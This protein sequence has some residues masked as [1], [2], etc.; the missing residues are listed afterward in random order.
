MRKNWQF[1]LW[2]ATAVTVIGVLLI[3]S[4][5]GNADDGWYG[6]A[7]SDAY[8]YI[9]M[10]QGD[11]I[12]YPWGGRWLVPRMASLADGASVG[13]LQALNYLF[14]FLAVA[15]I[16]YLAAD[17]ASSTSVMVGA[18]AFSATGVALLVL[19]QNPFLVD[20]G[21]LFVFALIGIA[22][23]RENYWA[24]AAVVVVGVTVKEV[25]IGFLLLLLLRRRWREL[26]I[27]SVLSAGLLY[28]GVVSS[29]PGSAL[30][31]EFSGGLVVKLA[32]GLGA[33]WLLAAVAVLQ[34]SRRRKVVG[35]QDLQYFSLTIVLSIAVLPLATDTSRLLVFALPAVVPLCA[36]AMSESGKVRIAAGV[37]FAIPAIVSVI[38]SR[39]TYRL[40][41]QPFE[42]LESWYSANIELIAVSALL[43][44]VGA[45]VVSWTA[46]LGLTNRHRV[47]ARS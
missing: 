39:F 2:F 40:R 7:S 18:L 35:R 9:A 42:Q 34:I 4:R 19:F 5:S 12:A 37:V 24:L 36:M 13:A 33:G 26:G 31:P 22:Y 1:L 30:L 29:A 16:T 17:Y 25:V 38:P 44:L 6:L 43:A 41:P 3:P 47:D 27:A 10:A 32:F 28:Y 11:A 46:I 21:G 8:R 15:A 23:R 45:V 14:L 20:S